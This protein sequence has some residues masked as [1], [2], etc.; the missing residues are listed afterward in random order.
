M[1]AA[2]IPP[3]LKEKLEAIAELECRTM[4]SVVRL[5]LESYV[6]QHGA[7]HPQLH[8]DIVAALEGVR[9]GEVEPYVQG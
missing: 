5:A 3:N 4:S 6:Q 8:A 9:R 1:V 2:K 7:I